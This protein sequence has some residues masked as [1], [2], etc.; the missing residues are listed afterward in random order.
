MERMSPHLRKL[1]LLPAD[2]LGL[3]YSRKPEEALW[4]RSK[5]LAARSLLQ[6]WMF[7]GFILTRKLPGIH[8]KCWELGFPKS[9]FCSGLLGIA[10]LFKTR[11]L[12][13]IGPDEQNSSM[14]GQA[15]S[16][17]FVAWVISSNLLPNCGDP[18]R[19]HTLWS[20]WEGECGVLSTTGWRGNQRDYLPVD[21][22]DFFCNHSTYFPCPSS[23]SP[24]NAWNSGMSPF[25]A[26]YN[27]GISQ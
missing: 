1:P 27:K 6:T 2:L 19:L 12:F 10:S 7:R 25:G 22:H 11:F 8:S 18:D 5:S 15:A 16:L 26:T 13:R 24:W 23:G 21:F 4:L 17:V 14:W 3:Y 9:V 20:I